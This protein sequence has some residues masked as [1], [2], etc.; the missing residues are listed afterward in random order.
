[1]HVP[2]SVLLHPSPSPRG[3]LAV[4]GSKEEEE[5]EEEHP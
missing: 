1:M 3:S 2:H 4:K 5:E